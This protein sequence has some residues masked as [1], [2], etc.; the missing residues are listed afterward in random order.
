MLF[1]QHKDPHPAIAQAATSIVSVVNEYILLKIKFQQNYQITGCS[2]RLG[3]QR[4]SS[5]Q[6][7]PE[8]PILFH[9]LNTT[10]I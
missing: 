8:I 6:L 4:P 7:F 9:L 2:P 5:D 10:G 1:L 3:V